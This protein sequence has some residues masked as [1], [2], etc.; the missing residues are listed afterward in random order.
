MQEEVITSLQ[1]PKIKELGL[2]QQKARHRVQSGRFVVEGAREL[3]ACCNAGYKI[4][5]LFF[6]P[7]IYSGKANT[8]QEVAKRFNCSAAKVFTVSEQLYSKIAY[9]STTEGVIA[10]VAARSL[11]LADVERQLPETPLIIVAEG[12]E[13]PGNIGALLRTSDACGADA[14]LL[15]NTT[16]DIYNPNIIRSSLGGI[17]TQKVV[18]C[19]SE[20]AI[21]WLKKKEITIYTA[22]LQDSKPYYNTDMA[23]ACAIVM[24]SEAEGLTQQWREASDCKIM[25]PMLGVLDS[26]NVSVSAAILC[27]EAVRQRVNNRRNSNSIDSSLRSE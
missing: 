4:E 24:G 23:G 10:E 8:A 27:Y 5:T 17:F 12:I 22:Q 20:E 1:N 9:R 16:K 19:T 15:C 6:C 18:C 25:I 14:V 11:T 21:K 2:L 13:K 3:E 7:Q 26:L